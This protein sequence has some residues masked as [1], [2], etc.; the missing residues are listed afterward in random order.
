MK[1]VGNRG[2]SF[3]RP[4]SLEKHDP[5]WV[6]VLE[7]H[8]VSNIR[9]VSPYSNSQFLFQWFSL[10]QLL[11]GSN[12]PPDVWSEGQALPYVSVSMSFT[13]GYLFM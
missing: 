13:S 9:V 12:D 5:D 4:T 3:Q 8:Q 7:P 11:S 6:S 1:G 2:Q 10:G